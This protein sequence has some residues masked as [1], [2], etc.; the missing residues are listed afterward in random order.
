MWRTLRAVGEPFF[1]EKDEALRILEAQ[2]SQENGRTLRLRD[3][4]FLGENI[5]EGNWP[6][7]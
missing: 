1:D 3:Q 2:I 4:P 5:P 6:T 7:P